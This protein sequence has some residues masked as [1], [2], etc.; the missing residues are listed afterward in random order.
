MSHI[1]LT[2]YER[3]NMNTLQTNSMRTVRKLDFLPWIAGFHQIRSNQTSRTKQWMKYVTI[4]GNLMY[5]AVYIC[6][7]R[8]LGIQKV[9]KHGWNIMITF[10]RKQCSPPVHFNYT[11]IYNFWIRFLMKGMS[12]VNRCLVEVWTGNKESWF[13][14]KACRPGLRFT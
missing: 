10:V 13:N 7:K 11:N 12:D 4:N 14:V 1:N 8:L 2:V 5:Y 6:I 9:V 3:S